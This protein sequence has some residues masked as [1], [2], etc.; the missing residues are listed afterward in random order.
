MR[1]SREQI[2]RVQSL[3]R[4]ARVRLLWQA[5]GILPEGSDAFEGID[6]DSGMYVQAA[7]HQLF[8]REAAL[9]F[10]LEVDVPDSR[11]LPRRTTVR[12]ANRRIAIAA[13]VASALLIAVFLWLFQSAVFDAPG[14][15]AANM[16]IGQSSVVASPAAFT[17]PGENGQAEGNDVFFFDGFAMIARTADGFEIYPANLEARFELDGAPVHLLLRHP[18]STVRVTGTKFSVDYRY[19]Y[20]VITLDEGSLEVR[21]HPPGS[22]LDGPSVALSGPAHFAFDAARA[23]RAELSADPAAVPVPTGPSAV[24]QRFNLR[25]GRVF[26]G[27]VVRGDR[28]G[29]TLRTRDGKLITVARSNLIHSEV[30]R[31]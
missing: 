9:L 13:A 5:E 2:Q 30:L 18:L 11:A 15:R 19:G 8:A 12:P 23:T 7:W 26:E 4:K 16:Q 3:S 29:L 25:D 31:E 14:F 20:G 28:D 17:L 10:P 27:Q 22:P 1:L 6:A 21:H 24:F